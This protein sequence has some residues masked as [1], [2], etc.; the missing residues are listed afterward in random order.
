LL[1]PR[2]F[3]ACLAQL[4]T[5]RALAWIGKNIIPIIQK[6]LVNTVD[7]DNLFISGEKG[8]TWMEFQNGLPQQY[9]N[10]TINF[11]T[12]VTQKVKE[13]ILLLKQNTNSNTRI[14]DFIIQNI[15]KKLNLYQNKAYYY[16]MRNIN[17]AN[18]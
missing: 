1:R 11:P 5:G 17:F 6:E 10:P 13:Y 14:F 15:R 12:E 3:A 18:K 9:I 7:I 8:G 16:L 4:G 2:V